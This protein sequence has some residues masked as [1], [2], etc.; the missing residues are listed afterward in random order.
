MFVLILLVLTSTAFAQTVTCPHPVGHLDYCRD[1][2]PCGEGVGDCDNDKQCETNLTCI[3][4]TGTDVCEAKTKKTTLAWDA[5]SPRDKVIGY[6]IYYGKQSRFDESLDP[7]AIT[8]ELVK[9]NC[10]DNQECIDSWY[11]YCTDPKDQ[12][13]DYDWFDY[14]TKIDV[15]NVLEYTITLP[16]GT[17]FFAATA[18]NKEK[19]E[20]K[21]SEELTQVI[22]FSA[23]NAPLNFISIKVV[24]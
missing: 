13:C 18:Y 3:Q 12:M 16:Y 8:T 23:P 14:D 1:C 20:S 11:K 17:Y 9:K 2:G 5:N 21:F 22:E 24:K 10:H 6:K 7:E 19:Q 15:K 4:V